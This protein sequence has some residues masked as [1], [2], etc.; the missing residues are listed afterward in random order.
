M[1]ANL[2][3]IALLL[4]LS[5]LVAFATSI[6]NAIPPQEKDPLQ[7]DPVELHALLE[8][9]LVLWV[10]ARSEDEYQTGHLSSALLLNEE[11]WNDLFPNL[12]DHW[13]PDQTIVV[14]C[15]GATC[16]LSKSVAIRLRE[17]MGVENVF[18]L[19]D[20]WQKYR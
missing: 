19:K 14:Y 7:I 18:F 2:S 6:V 17:E 9:R 8:S 13:A 15:S 11:N 1:K 4:I 3:R 20:N 16:E 10:D 5:A 12:L